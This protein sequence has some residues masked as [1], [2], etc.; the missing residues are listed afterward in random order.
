[1]YLADGLDWFRAGHMKSSK[2]VSRRETRQASRFGKMKLDKIGKI[3]IAVIM[4]CLVFVAAEAQQ[5]AY[6]DEGQ[7]V[8][9]C[10]EAGGKIIKIRE[11]DQSESDWCVISDKEAC[12]ADQVQGGKCMVTNPPPRVL[13]DKEQ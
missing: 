10:Q 2:Q 13:C 3:G 11:C 7:K 4:L 12:Y 5:G 8:S 9:E 1:M 6:E